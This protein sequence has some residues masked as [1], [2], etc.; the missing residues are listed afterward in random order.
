MAEWAERL[1]PIMGDQRIQTMWLRS[2][3]EPSVNLDTCHLLWRSALLGYGKDGLAQCQDNVTD[4]DYQVMLLALA[5]WFP[6]GAA[7]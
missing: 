2:M 5:A 3:V 7:L 1:S 6:S 4:C